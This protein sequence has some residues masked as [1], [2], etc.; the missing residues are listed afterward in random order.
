MNV[1]PAQERKT[2]LLGQAIDTCKV[3]NDL[4]DGLVLTEQSTP[5][6]VSPTIVETHRRLEMEFR[7]EM[8]KAMERRNEVLSPFTRLTDDLVRTIF[9]LINASVPL[10][11]SIESFRT[12]GWRVPV[13]LS[14]VCR[15]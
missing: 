11:G 6:T 2:Q 15:R 12:T 9:R 7:E 10:P 4:L 3:L 1:S 8:R 13:I 5:Y 14:H